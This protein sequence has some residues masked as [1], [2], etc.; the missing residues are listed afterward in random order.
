M[1]EYDL[2]KILE[3]KKA[4]RKKLAEMPFEEKLLIIEKM[5]ERDKLIEISRKELAEKRK[6]AS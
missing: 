3:S 4:Y 5:R 6:N 2:A 1:I